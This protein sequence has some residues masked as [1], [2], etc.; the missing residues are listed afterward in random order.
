MLGEDGDALYLRIGSA[1]GQSEPH[2]RLG[3]MIKSHKG[4]PGEVAWLLKTLSPLPEDLSL[5][6]SIHRVPHNYL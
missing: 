1:D 2:R 6:P 3:V 4:G 5:V